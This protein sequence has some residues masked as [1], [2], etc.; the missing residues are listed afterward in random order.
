[1]GKKGG[2]DGNTVCVECM[3]REEW[4]GDEGKSGAVRGVR[5]SFTSLKVGGQGNIGLEPIY[6]IHQQNPTTYT[7][8]GRL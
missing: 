7:I 2:G 6:F 1:M 3:G 4:G 8:S 5:I